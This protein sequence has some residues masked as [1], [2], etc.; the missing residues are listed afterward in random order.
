[1]TDRRPS[2]LFRLAIAFIAAWAIFL[3][4]VSALDQVPPDCIDKGMYCLHALGLTL[5]M[6]MFRTL[7]PWLVTSCL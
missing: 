3:V 2:V 4:Q 6:A 1:M 5:T 7:F